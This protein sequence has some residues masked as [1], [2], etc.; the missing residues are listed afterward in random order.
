MSNDG[1]NS[2]RLEVA[3][4][5]THTPQRWREKRLSGSEVQ[6]HLQYCIVVL[7]FGMWPETH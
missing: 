2:V 4:T 1:L 7:C 5:H 6:Q 3:G